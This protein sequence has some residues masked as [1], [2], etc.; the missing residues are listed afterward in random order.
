[1][2]W[3]VFGLV[4]LALLV[5]VAWPPP[6][7][8]SGPLAGRYQ[9]GGTSRTLYRWTGT[10]WMVIGWVAPCGEKRYFPPALIIW[11]TTPLD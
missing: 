9:A 2:D 1:M 8:K 5:Y 10:G 3:L 6:G 11:A 7:S 4:L